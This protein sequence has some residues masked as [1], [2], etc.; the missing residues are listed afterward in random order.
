M[1]RLSTI[2]ILPVVDDLEKPQFE[3]ILSKSYKIEILMAS[4]SESK[5]K[6]DICYLRNP[7]S[8]IS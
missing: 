5:T 4:K 2:N 8:Y 6:W 1:E 3:E 7:I